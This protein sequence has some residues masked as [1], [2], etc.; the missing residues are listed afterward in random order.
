MGSKSLNRLMSAL[1]SAFARAS[2]WP[3]LNR[4]RGV[5]SALSNAFC[6]AVGLSVSSVNISDALRNASVCLIFFA[7]ALL[8][9]VSINHPLECSERS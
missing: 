5:A 9:L 6:L 7:F 3:K 4:L 2:W 1:I 8:L